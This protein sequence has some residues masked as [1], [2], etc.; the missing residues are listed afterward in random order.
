MKNIKTSYVSSSYK[1]FIKKTEKISDSNDIYIYISSFDGDTM[2]F[3]PSGDNT[4]SRYYLEQINTV[5]QR[6]FSEQKTYITLRIK[7][8]ERVQDHPGLRYNTYRQRQDA[9]DSLCVLTAVACIIDDTD[10][11]QPAGICHIHRASAG[12]SDIILSV[13]E[14]N[15]TDTKDIEFG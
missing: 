12:L 13:G 6:L 3:K 4:S 7:G 11:H 9:T 14:D 5:N 8:Q 15:A 2:Y 1:D 10:T